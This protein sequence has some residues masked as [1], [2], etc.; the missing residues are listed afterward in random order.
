MSNLAI[1]NHNPLNIRKGYCPWKGQTG[2]NK[3][4][5]VFL[6]WFYGYRAALVLLTRTYFRKLGLNT[7]EK[8]VNRWAPPTENDTENY[9]RLVSQ[10]MGV[11]RDQP[12]DLREL[13]TVCS[14]VYAMGIVE[15]GGIHSYE[16]VRKYVTE[17]YEKG[18]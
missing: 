16:A 9:I 17:L 14:L 11:K 5:C 6:N 1:D 4:F 10:Q 15:N 3:G 7:I 12:L 2:T 8:I 13:N 18:F